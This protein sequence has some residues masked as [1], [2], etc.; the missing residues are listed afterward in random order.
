MS[1]ILK[2]LKLTCFYQQIHIGWMQRDKTGL[3]ITHPPGMLLCLYHLWP[4]LVLLVFIGFLMCQNC[5]CKCRSQL[6]FISALEGQINMS[7]GSLLDKHYDTCYKESF[8]SI[9]NNGPLQKQNQTKAPRTGF[10]EIYPSHEPPGKYVADHFFL[11]LWGLE[12]EGSQHKT[13]TLRGGWNTVAKLRN[14]EP[15]MPESKR[16]ALPLTSCVTLASYLTS[17]CFNILLYKMWMI[18]RVPTSLLPCED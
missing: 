9:R 12:E 3:E 14:S 13:S 15:G 8:F 1:G 4:M 10:S 11:Y 16:S 17:L 2:E 6:L 5:K 7:K 18:R